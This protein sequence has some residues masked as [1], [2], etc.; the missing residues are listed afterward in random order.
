[1]PSRGLTAPQVG[2]L[3]ECIPV[4]VP[5]TVHRFTDGGGFDA[6][7]DAPH[8]GHPLSFTGGDLEALGA[9]WMP[10]LRR[11]GLDR[12][13]PAE[14]PRPDHGPESLTSRSDLNG[15]DH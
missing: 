14:R 2:D 7:A 6:L 3:L 4:T 11:G 12:A 10:R 15:G 9:C 5:D 13:R 1:M 8:P